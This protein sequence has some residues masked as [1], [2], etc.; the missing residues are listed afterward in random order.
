[1]KHLVGM[2]TL[3]ASRRTAD[4]VNR[5]VIQLVD[6]HIVS[7]M[8]L[9]LHLVLAHEPVGTDHNHIPRL[10]GNSSGIMIIMTL[11]PDSFFRSE[12]PRDFEGRLQPLLYLSTDCSSLVV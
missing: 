11:L 12:L 5:P 10:Q 9:I 8:P 1:M 7:I 2:S 3:V 6:N 4:L